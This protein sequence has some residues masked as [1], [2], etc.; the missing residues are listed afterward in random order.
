MNF[1]ILISA[2]KQKARIPGNNNL[3]RIRRQLKMKEREG[4][5]WSQDPSYYDSYYSRPIRTS[6]NN[7]R[8]VYT[9]NEQEGSSS[10]HNVN[11]DNIHIIEFNRAR[12]RPASS[13]S[14]QNTRTYGE[15][16]ERNSNNRG[17]QNPNYEYESENTRR[18]DEDRQH[19]FTASL[20]RH[21]VSEHDLEYSDHDI[22]EEKYTQR[23]THHVLPKPQSQQYD[24]E[25]RPNYFEAF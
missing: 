7:N 22:D 11:W 13:A 23:R 16:E 21:Y 14:S 20:E 8:D 15:S 1:C 3:L 2:I 4:R 12:G 24:Q 5:G 10:N 25:F 18:I 17:Y 9:S 6:N 19:G